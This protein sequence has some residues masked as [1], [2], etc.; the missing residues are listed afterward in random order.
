MASTRF[1][2]RSTAVFLVGVLTAACVDLFHSTDFAT[3]CTA[4]PTDPQCLG[5]GGGP[6]TEGGPDVET[7]VDAKR[8]HPDFCSWSR[9]EVYKQ[10]TLA[11]AR[12]GACVG[13]FSNGSGSLTGTSFGQCVVTAQLAFD[14][15]ANPSLRPAG[16]ADDFWS[17]LSTATTCSQ[18]AA[19]TYPGPGGVEQCSIT[20][21]PFEACGSANNP[22]V[23]IKCDVNGDATRAEPC[24]MYG[25]ICARMGD[26]TAS[27]TGRQGY[28]CGVV[29]CSGTMASDCAG[30]RDKGIDCASVGATCTEV[31]GAP[32][33]KPPT[34]TTCSPD[35]AAVCTGDKVSACIGGTQVEIDCSRLGQPTG[36]T[37]G[38]P[39]D[40][41]TAVPLYALGN[42][43]VD[44]PGSCTETD[45]N[46]NKCTNTVLSGCARGRPVTF[47]CNSLKMKCVDTGTPPHC[48]N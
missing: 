23:H 25:Q 31:S 20:K 2:V 42:A 24:A 5:D 9:V 1:A 33:C 47:D 28:T 40:T 26:S 27:C 11:C 18:V 34:G 4:N 8:M 43:C 48:S 29:G 3:L 30:N 7:G 45:V 6:L 13:P 35:T 21:G 10:A 16:I 15:T 22:D 12:L 44:V 19:C 32:A 17:C 38:L 41:T 46:A 14:C 39:C 37:A 36:G